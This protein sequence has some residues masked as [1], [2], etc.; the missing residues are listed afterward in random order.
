M[1]VKNST[2]GSQPTEELVDKHHYDLPS[3]TYDYILRLEFSHYD[4]KS[5]GTISAKDLHFLSMV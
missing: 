3:C 2:C 4:Y 5:R 1:W